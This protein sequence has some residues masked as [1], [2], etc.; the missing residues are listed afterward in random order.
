MDEAPIFL[1]GSERSGTTLL[2]L[3]LDSHP[4]IAFNLE[5]EF[6]VDC[7][8]DE[9][10]FPDLV[11]YREYLALDRVFAHSHFDVD[12]GLDYPD[13]M[14]AFLEQKR[15]RNKKSIVGATVHRNFWRLHFL[16]PEAR[17]IHILRD[18]RDV[19]RSCMQMGWAGNMLTASAIW[20]EAEQQW[21][22]LEPT[23]SKVQF[24]EVRYEE[25]VTDA[26]Q[27]L[28]RLC[29]F[30]GVPFSEKMFDYAKTSSYSL[31]SSDRIGQWKSWLS[32]TEIQLA[33]LTIGEMLQRRGYAPSGLPR[34][35]LSRLQR[36][37]LRLQ[38]RIFRA[39]FQRR[40]LG[41]ALYLSD[42]LAR[43]L[44]MVKWK[45]HTQRQINAIEDEHIK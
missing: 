3:L 25:L 17:Y 34:I 14:N 36:I 40:R 44:G 35:R 16:W 21:D 29:D 18:G 42:F 32:P 31:P 2:R 30:I 27:V 5:S 1:V 12:V 8:D 11:S 37:V 41:N 13:L 39:A 38:D 23:L 22:R 20:L 6:L 28:V 26:T 33:E 19:A 45:A 9:G 7:M 24:T 43:R 10:S 4:R 15:M